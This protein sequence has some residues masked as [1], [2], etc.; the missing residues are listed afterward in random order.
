M[1]FVCFLYTKF[2]KD[3]LRHSKLNKGGGHRQRGDSI[4]LLFFL[5]NNKS[6]IGRENKY[7]QDPAYDRL[8]EKW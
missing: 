1:E 5:E 4:S 3:W 6:R 8:L 2:H 7:Y